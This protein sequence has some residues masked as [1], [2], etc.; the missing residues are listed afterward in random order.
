MDAGLQ[1]EDEF[2]RIFWRKIKRWDVILNHPVNF[3]AVKA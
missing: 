2:K 3:A 1:N